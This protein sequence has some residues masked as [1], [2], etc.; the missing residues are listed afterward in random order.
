MYSFDELEKLCRSYHRKRLILLVGGVVILG[1]VA[2]WLYLTYGS[3]PKKNDYEVRTQA[4]KEKNSSKPQPIQISSKPQCFALQMLYSYEKFLPNIEKEKKRLE[5]SGLDCYIKIKKETKEAFLRCNAVRTKQEIKP[6]LEVAK[7]LTKHP[8]IINEECRYAKRYKEVPKIIVKK[9]K[10]VE[11]A[12]PPSKPPVV[13]HKEEVQTIDN[14]IS[15]NSVDIDSLKKLYNER[16]NYTLA[17]KIARSYYDKGDFQR[18]L[19]WAK[20]AN[21]LDREREG[22]WVLYA[23]SLY[24]LGRKKEARQLLGLYLEYHNSQSVQ[25]LLSEWSR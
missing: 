9:V 22:A 18:A 7:L 1:G 19:Q 15:A 24:A 6:F 13:T 2:A 11:K 17:M 23:R 14:V 16:K 20:R 5:D 25:K 3:Y 10:R 8:Y 4:N 12:S 21:K